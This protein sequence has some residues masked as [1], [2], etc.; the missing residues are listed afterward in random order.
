MA[1]QALMK[2]M[3]DKRDSFTVIMAGYAERLPELYKVNPGFESRVGMKLTFKDY[4]TEELTHMVADMLQ[5]MNL[6]VS[7]EVMG[8]IDLYIESRQ[9]RGGL[10]NGRGARTLSERIARNVHVDDPNRR[11][12]KEKDIPM[13]MRLHALEAEKIIP[14]FEANYSGMPR[15]KKFM[16]DMYKKQLATEEWRKSFENQPEGKKR[17]DSEIGVWETSPCTKNH[18]L[19]YPKRPYGERC[20]ITGYCK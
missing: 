8:K 10:G 17:Q 18:P 16:R 13:P 12:V 2:E 20:R 1:L 5:T 19:S 11:D 14:D 7:P 9:Q 15:V 6:S 3:E 4:T